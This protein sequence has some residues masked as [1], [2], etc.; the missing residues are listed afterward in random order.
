MA[1][2]DEYE[3]EEGRGRFGLIVQPTLLAL[4][5]SWSNLGAYSSAMII[6]ATLDFCLA[7]AIDWCFILPRSP[8]YGGL[9]EAAVKIAK[10]HLF[11]ICCFSL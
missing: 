5:M 11:A 7:Q 9:W 4:A 6:R 3:L 8:H 2:K 10:H 1:S